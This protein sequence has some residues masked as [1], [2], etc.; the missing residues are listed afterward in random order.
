MS[1][2]NRP[3]DSVYAYMHA[4]GYVDWYVYD[5]LYMYVNI[6]AHVYSYYQ[7][8]GCSYNIFNQHI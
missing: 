2:Q 8:N 1:S 4:C 3:F 6:Y 7:I 5:S